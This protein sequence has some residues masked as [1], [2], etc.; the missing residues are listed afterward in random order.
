MGIQNIKGTGLDFVYR[1]QAWQTCHRLCTQLRGDDLSV[2]NKALEQLALFQEHGRLTEEFVRDTIAAVR[3]MAHAQTELFQAQL[4]VIQDNL[5]RRIAELQ[6]TAT[7]ARESGLMA[8]LLGKLEEF[9]DS[10]DAVRRRKKADLVYREMVGRRISA[11]R[12]II[13]LQEL[14]KRQKGGWLR[15]SINSTVS[16]SIIVSGLRALLAARR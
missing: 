13:E 8:R 9:L 2:S 11:D 14:T 16:Q 4:D 7:A 10:G 12:A 1:W 5:E 15:K 6:S 3:S